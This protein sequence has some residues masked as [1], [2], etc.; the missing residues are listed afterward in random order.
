MPQT[1]QP[2][3]VSTGN[4][5]KVSGGIDPARL[6]RALSA[7]LTPALEAMGDKE[8]ASI[9]EDLSVPVERGEDGLI[10]RSSPGQP[11]RK[12]FGILQEFVV[13]EVVAGDNGLPMLRIEST[14]PTISADD[15]PDAPRVL[16]MEIDRP[17]MAPALVRM[18]GYALSFIEKFLSKQ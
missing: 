7:M 15:D 4:P 14:R 1:P 12:E 9:R 17:Y 18:K 13:R 11:P 8:V 3:P 10:V 5:A 16:E 2:T 6:A